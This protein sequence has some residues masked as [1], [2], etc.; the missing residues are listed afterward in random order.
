M[1]NKL[2]DAL[3]AWRALDDDSRDYAITVVDLESEETGASD[4]RDALKVVLAVLRAAS[5]PE[6]NAQ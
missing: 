1:S 3:A 4:Y 2:T 5:E 6:R